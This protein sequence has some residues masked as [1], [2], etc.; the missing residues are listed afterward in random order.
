MTD[1]PRNNRNQDDQDLT[2]DQEGNLGGES[3]D[4]DQEDVTSNMDEDTEDE[5]TAM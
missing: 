5:E 1:D 3:S 4:I 2:E